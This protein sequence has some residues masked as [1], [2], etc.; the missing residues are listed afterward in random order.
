MS[1][2]GGA[3]WCNS[4][5][6]LRR[7]GGGRHVV[8]GPSRSRGAL[9]GRTGLA[10]LVEIRVQDYR[11]VDGTFD[12]ISSIG[13]FEH[14]GLAQLGEYFRSLHR[15]LGPG[16]RVLN[17]GISSPPRRGTRFRRRGF[18]DRYVFPDAELHEIGSVVSRMQVAGLEVR[19]V[20]SLREHYALTLRQWVANL[21]RNWDDAVAAGGIGRARCG[22]STWPRPP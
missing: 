13:M 8:D 19:H 2:A 22:G 14:V 7:Q 16:G 21:E 1:A 9:D 4:G 10:D 15:L 5:P 11:D 17:H 20:E 18:I 6:P 12:A 3:G